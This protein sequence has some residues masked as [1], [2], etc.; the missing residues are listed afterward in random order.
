MAPPP[1]AI[2]C[3]HYPEL[4]ALR[5]ALSAGTPAPQVAIVPAAD[6]APPLDAVDYTLRLLQDWLADDRLSETRLVLVTRGAVAAG[7]EDVDL[8]GAAVWGLAR[9]AQTE[10]PGRLILI[11]LD[12]GEASARA[13]P[14][15][16][17][18]GEPQVAVRDGTLLAAR[19]MR[20]DISPAPRRQGPAWD[21]DGTVLITGGT[22]TLGQLLARHLVTR[23]GTR[24]LLLASRRGPAAP[25]APELAAEL[26][27]HGA[28]VTLAACDTADRPALAALLAAIPAAH[29]LTAVIHAAGALADATITALTP[30]ALDTTLRPKTTAAWHL[31]DLTRHHDLAAFIMF[32]SCAGTLGSAGQASYAAANAALDALAARRHAQ[33]LPAR[34]LAWGLWDTAT[35]MTSHMTTADRTRLARAGLA[36]MPDHQ[37]LTLFDTALTT[38]A[39]PTLIPA[40]LDHAALH[41]AARTTTGIPPALRTLIRTPPRRATSE[42]D[43]GP[44]G[45]SFA[46]R[47]AGAGED[48]ERLVLDLVRTHI[49]AVL[50]HGSAELVDS[51]RGLLD[52]G[53]DSLTAVE[54]RNRL[55]SATGLRLPSTLVFDYPTPQAITGHLWQELVP[56]AAREAAP[57][58]AELDRIE[59][60]MT[61]AAAD[62]IEHAAVAARLQ[63]LLWKWS[64]QGAAGIP[65][66]GTAEAGADLAS[67]TDDE[68]FGLLDQE[69]QTPNDDMGGS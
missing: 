60:A 3:A 12:G 11:D 24:H 5:A 50:G 54:L 31:H 29:P 13:L 64:A 38:P 62:D 47:L 21:P 45:A 63:Q 43:A 39:G 18:S 35:G 46:E 30:Q 44:D 10:N 22:G 27:A 23:H 49:A 14:A 9:T 34:S 52:M 8:A 61:T 2:T 57:L 4:A 25:G 67:A 53:F 65:D 6:G 41:R 69:L 42:P 59:S 32:S 15:A 1:D 17:A 37:A 19:L 58:L 16:V 7:A 55:G 26:E 66:G 56:G 36:P 48:R 51:D 68:L 33:G 20:H 28:S 40:R